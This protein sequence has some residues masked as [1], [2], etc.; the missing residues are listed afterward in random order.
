M[1][2]ICKQMRDH[3]GNILYC[4][5]RLLH[6]DAPVAYQQISGDRVLAEAADLG[7][8]ASNDPVPR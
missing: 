7:F 4:V 8:Q 6:F 5:L 2:V 1:H 3:Q